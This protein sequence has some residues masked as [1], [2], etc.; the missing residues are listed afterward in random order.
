MPITTPPHLLDDY[1]GDTNHFEHVL[2]TLFVPAVEKAGF[3]AIPP[4]SKGSVVIQGDIISKLRTSEM[5][6]CDISTLNANVF[7]ELGI[8]TALHKPVAMVKDEITQVYPFDTSPLQAEPYSST[9]KHWEVTAE[10]PKLAAHI[11]ACVD[12][13]KGK[14]TLWSYFGL[15]EAAT[16][17]DP[18]TPIEQLRLEIAA[19]KNQLQTPPRIDDIAQRRK[20]N[21]VMGALLRIGERNNLGIV[22]VAYNGGAVELVVRREISQN[23]LSE[24]M[25]VDGVRSLRWHL[26]PRD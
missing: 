19:L 4:S 1:D 10:L 22:H 14:N 25:S 16:T 17:A 5:V 3:T 26:A 11:K 6:L 9:M 21:E 8:R 13:S 7:F 20:T 24:M 15:T 2:E 18:G 12:Q 23:V